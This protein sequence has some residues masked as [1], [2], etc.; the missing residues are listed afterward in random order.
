MRAFLIR[1]VDL[2]GLGAVEPPFLDRA[3]GGR[4][5]ELPFTRTCW[6]IKVNPILIDALHLGDLIGEDGE[7]LDA[8]AISKCVHI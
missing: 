1:F 4:L 5:A 7:I 3:H 8:E 2:L 6:S